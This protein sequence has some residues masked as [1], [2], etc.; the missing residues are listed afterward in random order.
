MLTTVTRALAG[1]LCASALV[2]C[3]PNGNTSLGASRV[4]TQ[5]GSTVALPIKP[6]FA[7]SV[8]SSAPAAAATSAATDRDGRSPAAAAIDARRARPA[9][10]R[11][12][13]PEVAAPLRRLASDTDTETMGFVA[14]AAASV[15]KRPA[16]DDGAAIGSPAAPVTAIV[17]GDVQCPYTARAV[18]TLLGLQARYGPDHVRL[19]WRNLP[20]SFH[21]RARAAAQA[22]EAVNVLAGGDA[23]WSL[24][25]AALEPGADLGDESLEL[26]ARRAGAP[27][28]TY[29]WLAGE[30]GTETAAT[31]AADEADAKDLGIRSVPYVL[32]NGE[33][34]IGAQPASVYAA[35]IER[36]LP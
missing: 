34:V 26:L 18:T 11:D 27:P 17:F 21:R 23:A 31:I 2:A 25:Q 1:L 35:L 29:A 10:A 33:P 7:L 36:S 16:R 28:S 14:L 9:L 22:A 30:G 24:L 4:I 6:A 8:G 20:L 5:G 12:A 13:K 3:R 15:A 32:L 19:V